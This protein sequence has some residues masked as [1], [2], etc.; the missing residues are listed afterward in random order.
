MNIL[1]Y[2]YLQETA[3]CFCETVIKVNRC[4]K[5]KGEQKIRSTNLSQI[6]VNLSRDPEICRIWS[7]F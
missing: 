6:G 5:G 7:P 2:S 3:G 4:C 1:I